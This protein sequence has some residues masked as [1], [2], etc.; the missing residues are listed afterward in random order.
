MIKVLFQS[1]WL[2][3]SDCYI[4]KNDYLYLLVYYEMNPEKMNA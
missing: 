1:S 4:T 3:A 2:P